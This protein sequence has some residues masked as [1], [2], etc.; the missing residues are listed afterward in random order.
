DQ[1]TSWGRSAEDLGFFSVEAVVAEKVRS[2]EFPAKGISCI[3]TCIQY[4][5]VPVR[6][7]ALKTGALVF[8]NILA[9]TLPAIS[10]GLKAEIGVLIEVTDQTSQKVSN[11]IPNWS[12]FIDTITN[13]DSATEV[14]LNASIDNSIQ[15]AKRTGLELLFEKSYYDVQLVNLSRFDGDSNAMFVVVGDV[16]EDLARIEQIEYKVI[17]VALFGLLLSELVLLAVLWSPLKRI[18]ETTDALPLLADGNYKQTRLL[19][20]KN[21]AGVV[22]NDEV[23]NL[24]KGV[25][26]LS[27]QLEQ[28]ELEVNSG[29]NK[30]QSTINALR[31]ERDFVRKL[32]DTAQ[33]II[34]THTV[35]G[36]VKTLNQYAREKL[37]GISQFKVSKK[38]ISIFTETIEREEVSRNIQRLATGKLD[39]FRSETRLVLKNG[40]EK[41]IAWVHSPIYRGADTEAQILSIGIDITDRKTAENQI[42]WLADHDPLTGLYNRRY[43]QEEFERML[44]HCI[45]Y[46][47]EG[48]LMF[49]DL[50]NFKYV[51]DTLG[52]QEGDTLIRSIG[53]LLSKES[54]ETDIVARLGGDE[55]A[56]AIQDID[57]KGAIQYAKKIAE[58][59]NKQN[60]KAG[61]VDAPT[62]VSIGIS[63]FP[64]QG[65]SV[66]QLLAN[67]D[68]AMYQAK[69]DGKSRWHIFSQ[70]D[71]VRE[72]MEFQMFWRRRIETAIKEENFALEYQPIAHYGSNDISHYEV[73]IR[74]KDEVENL[75]APNAFIHIAESTGLIAGIDRYVLK[76]TIQY[77]FHEKVMGRKISIAMNLSALTFSD[78]SFFDL[79]VD[80]MQKYKI[81]PTQLIFEITET[82]ALANYRYAAR[83]MQSVKELGC[84]FAL[85]DFGVGFSSFY[86]LRK[87]PVD[88]I[89]IDGSFIRNIAT[90]KDDQMLVKNIAKL[91]KGFNKLTIAEYVESA[92]IYEMLKDYDIDLVQG[93]YV[94]KPS[95]RTNIQHVQER[96][97]T[98]T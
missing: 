10:M 61:A 3:Q 11:A 35:Q 68:F 56:I 50:D 95:P 94:G 23:T 93:F 90:N 67:A 48:A 6:I 15:G 72:K 17:L 12:V 26:V 78:A 46:N 41:Y 16:T 5:A 21:G 85:D 80:C 4:T 7:S 53:T 52:H 70:N 63:L 64:H 92:E 27:Q 25:V 71:Q 22:G 29:R 32:L 44:K 54:R 28:L 45:R 66:K 34:V 13:R 76:N 40:E 19:L 87:L 88:Y 73:L 1:V 69:V 30:L 39:T 77:L 31:T 2:G 98:V 8:G 24:Q 82:A 37:E 96:E 47:T 91:A 38:F 60:V 86:Y 36:G 57:R 81:D 75:I 49:L 74:M 51:N 18:K 65:S 62:S 58:K 84:R 79:L 20:T 14:L 83:L 42:A 9:N 97:E 55:F 43:F 89:K 59:V 33:A